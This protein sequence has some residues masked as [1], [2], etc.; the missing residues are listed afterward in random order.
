[1]GALGVVGV[2]PA[3]HGLAGMVDAEEQ[4]LVEKL[5]AHPTVERFAVAVLHGFA[6]GDVALLHLY[7]LRPFQDRVRGELGAI[8]PTEGRTG[9]TEGTVRA[10]FLLQAR[11]V[12]GG[13]GQSKYL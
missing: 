6:G 13:H 11:I 7:L 2:G 1:M 10:A 5:V 8:A 3:R 12:R 4:G 9:A